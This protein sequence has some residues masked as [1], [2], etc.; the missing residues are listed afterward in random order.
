[1]E[2]TTVSA[3]ADG[4]D[5]LLN[6]SEASAFVKLQP[7][8]IYQLTSLRKIPHLKRGR[9][10]YFSK[11]ELSQWLLEGRVST[12]SELDALAESRR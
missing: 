12:Q 4:S 9:K 5:T 10:L 11:S 8:W 3:I 2:N 7:S 1:M 6:L